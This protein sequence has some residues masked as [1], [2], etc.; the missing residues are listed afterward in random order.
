ML[1]FSQSVSGR[2][3]YVEKGLKKK[4]KQ[5]KNVDN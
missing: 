1:S 5:M 2:G 4:K 3:V